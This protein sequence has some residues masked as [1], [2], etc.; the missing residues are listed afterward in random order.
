MQE[1]RRIFVLTIH[2]DIQNTSLYSM[3]INIL[4]VGAGIGG[5]ALAILLQKSDPRHRIT[6]VE[7][8][9]SLRASGQ[10]I[11]IKNQA[12]DI[13]KK[14][15]LL[16]AI[17]ARCVSETGLEV[18]SATGKPIAEFGIS[19][20][21]EQRL[22]LTSEYEIMRGDIINVLYT[23]SCEQNARIQESPEEHGG[24]L[25]YEF[26]NTITG[27]T[28]DNAS[29]GVTFAKGMDR[30]Y[31]LVIGADGQGSATRRLAFGPDIRFKTCMPL[32][33]HAAYYSIPSEAGDGTLART[34]SATKSRMIFTR[35]S[36]RPVTQVLLFTMQG[37]AKLQ[38]IYKEPME[39]QKKAF[40]DVFRGA[41]WNMKRLLDGLE[42]S[43]DFYAN[44][45]VQI[46]MDKL[47]TGRVALLGDAGHCPSPF[48][49]M[50][51]A[52]AIIGAYVL[53]GELARHT[54]SSDSH[55]I[56]KA[57]YSYDSNM[58]KPIQQCQKL[59]PV[60]L[61]LLFPSTRL[62]VWM[63]QNVAWFMSKVA[64]AIQNGSGSDQG[65]GKG[66]SSSWDLPDYPELLLKDHL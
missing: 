32:G 44:D 29:V 20:A 2:H 6:I 50:G 39:A 34:Y 19:P 31:D 46:K 26:D 55:D 42:K 60:P 18:L 10:Q 12:V 23:A 27:L 58:R 37:T 14:L 43:N 5:I 11:D 57:L 22:T 33:V 52:G 65:D 48:T 53:A 21:G 51:T 54:N 25:R 62:G 63:L 66:N 61:R 1:P 40:A 36:N 9:A 59:S 15:E 7:R 17:K 47:Y 3:P 41:G 38:D 49:G 4:I 56:S 8:H 13:L 28:Q 64:P 24:F 45:L 30:S 35:S 16:E